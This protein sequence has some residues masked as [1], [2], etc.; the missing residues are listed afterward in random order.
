MSTR[1]DPPQP[2][3]PEELW[4]TLGLEE[5]SRLTF[6]HSGTLIDDSPIS[7][8]GGLTWEQLPQF[9]IRS[10]ELTFNESKK[11][12]ELELKE[13]IGEGGMGVVQQALQVPLQREVAI[14]RLRGEQHG[15]Q[16]RMALLRE[17]WITGSLEHPNVIPIYALGSY[18]DGS[19][20]FVMKRVEG[21]PWTEVMH[22]PKH[23]LR[24]GRDHLEWN[25]GILMQVC[26]AVHFAHSRGILHRDL[27]PDNVMIGAFG[28]V[29]LLDWGIAVSLHEDTALPL[30][31]VQDIGAVSGTP[32][33]MAPEMVR[34][35]LKHTNERT[36]VYLLGS[37]LHEILTGHHRHIGDVL[38]EVM[39]RA[40]LSEPYSYKDSIPEEL[41]E[42]C[43]RATH[44][45]PTERFASAQEFQHSLVAFLEH[46][47]SVQLCTQAQEALRSFCQMTQGETA[48]EESQRLL[49][50]GTFSEARFGFQ[51]ALKIWPGNKEA[52]DG[53]LQ[54]HIA[55]TE[56]E[57][58]R[59]DYNAAFLFYNAIEAPP[60]ELTLRLQQLRKEDEQ[61]AVEL[62]ELRKQ[63]EDTDQNIGRRTR[64]FIM[65]VFALLF[66]PLGFS[67]GHCLQW[68]KFSH[69]SSIGFGVSFLSLTAFFSI[70][71]R[72]TMTRTAVN[73]GVLKTMWVLGF[74]LTAFGIGGWRMGIS[75]DKLFTFTAL[76]LGLCIGI[77]ASLLDT[78]LFLS[79]LLFLLTFLLMLCF[80][81]YKF[82]IGSTGDLLALLAIMSAWKPETW[83]RRQA[84]EW[85]RQQKQKLEQQGLS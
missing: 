62:E 13:T 67:Y 66:V 27:K 30:P 37:I 73:R 33:Y 78:K 3:T 75:P 58:R 50:Y 40:A 16:Q 26:N 79:S 59:G 18:I 1:L 28:E 71:A 76:Y 45:D 11:Q 55:I 21:V 57:L 81:L 42:V 8:T 41:A 34:L 64:S 35:D 60:E 48:V 22:N 15:D 80:P 54:S 14:K 77:V 74:A 31:R 84:E 46:R 19:P 36:D 7:S 53:L 6:N 4:N 49:V 38:M 85:L 61:K 68:L 44:I 69:L 29:Y 10:P 17:A 5:E 56:M 39:F 83:S 51:Q 2:S 43:N 82:E 25:L 63:F 65:L 12:V 70:W 32:G 47:D 52:E 9:T 72:E 20:M 23:P 24:Q